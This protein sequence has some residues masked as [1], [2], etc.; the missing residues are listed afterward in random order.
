VVDQTVNTL[1]SRGLRAQAQGLG[2]GRKVGCPKKFNNPLQA[3]PYMRTEAGQKKM[4][5]HLSKISREEHLVVKWEDVARKL[6][7]DV[8]KS[9][10]RWTVKA[11][12]RR[13]LKLRE[14]NGEKLNAE[15]MFSMALE[16]TKGICRALFRAL[17]PTHTWLRDTHPR[18]AQSKNN[19]PQYSRGNIYNASKEF[20]GAPTGRPPNV[21]L[22]EK[23]F[24]VRRKTSPT[25]GDVGCSI[26]NQLRNFRIV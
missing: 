10:C 22:K 9:V 17:P 2:F 16:R 11:E 3:V 21:F 12:T 15:Q 24:N 4:D 20:A 6:K 1:F 13:E 18:Y 7:A 26:R 19:S 25:S 8:S 14:E 23:R 5:E